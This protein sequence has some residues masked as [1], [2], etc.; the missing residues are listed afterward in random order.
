MLNPFL[1][2]VDLATDP[3]IRSLNSLDD[4]RLNGILGQTI[5]EDREP[6][7]EMVRYYLTDTV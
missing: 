6:I 2:I 3:S 1:F 4:L 7:T 5:L